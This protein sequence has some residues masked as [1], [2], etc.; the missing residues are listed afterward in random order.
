MKLSP[1]RRGG[2]EIAESH[3]EERFEE[4]WWYCLSDGDQGRS[5]QTLPT[6]LP[7]ELIS[8]FKLI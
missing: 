2:G 7:I 1:G 3:L 5:L 4:S 8:Q 6:L